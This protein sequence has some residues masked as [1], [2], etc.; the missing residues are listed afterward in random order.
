MYEAGLTLLKEK[1]EATKTNPTATTDDHY[2]IRITQPR[3]V[4]A[5]STAKRVCYEMGEGDGQ[6]IRGKTKNKGNLV[7]YQTRYFTMSIFK[8]EP[9]VRDFIYQ[10][11]KTATTY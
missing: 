2:V 10:P 4:P 8:P 1:R 11:C 7:T 5:V 3:R 9:L 6:M